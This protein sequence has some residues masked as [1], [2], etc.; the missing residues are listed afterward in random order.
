MVRF[1]ALL[2]LL[3][4]AAPLAAEPADAF[5][6]LKAL[7]P[8]EQ[9]DVLWLARCVLSESNRADE[10]RY[11]AWVVRN[12]VE[13]GY[14]GT[15][16]REVVLEP[17]QF[18]AFNEPSERRRYLTGLGE[19]T[20]GDKAWRSVLGIAL[21]ER[22]VTD[23][24]SGDVGD[25]VPAQ[26]QRPEGI[27]PGERTDVTDRVVARAERAQ[28]QHRLEALHDRGRLLGVRAGAHTEVDVRSCDLEGLEEAVRH[29]RVVVLPRVQQ[30]GLV[31]GPPAEPAGRVRG[32]ED[33]GLRPEPLAPARLLQSGTVV[34]D[35]VVGLGV[36]T[37]HR[38]APAGDVPVEPQHARVAHVVADGRDRVL[39]ATVAHC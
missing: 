2:V 14:R 28:V 26:I 16:Y 10:Q 25:R 29:P 11:V 36:D 23:A 7:K 21:D 17:Y 30:D 1:L 3:V 6:R 18:S 13:T 33:R 8:H 35:Q 20:R 39:E 19:N 5:A 34:G 31:S 38:A 9:D 15:S 27:V 37:E 4:G 32:A 22:A 24:D 12:R